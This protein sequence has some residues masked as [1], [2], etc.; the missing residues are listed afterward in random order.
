V[1]RIVGVDVG[2][3]FT[4]VVMLDDDGLTGRKV[5]TTRNQ[6]DGVIAAMEQARLETRDLF[7]HG[8]TAGTNALLE[9]TGARTALVTTA[10]F[11]DIIEIA[12]QARPSLYDPFD[13]RP[14]PL[15]PPELRFGYD[16]DPAGLTQRLIEAA[17]EAIALALVRSHLDPEDELDLGERL[18]LGTG[19]PVSVGAVVSPEFREYERVATT[20]L[21]AYLTP[22]LALYLSRL[23]R[24]LETEQRLVM[25]S[26]GGLLTFASAT[27]R[28]GRLALS[29]P[30]AGAVAATAMG[31]A[32]GY[33]SVISFDMGG[34]STDVCRIHGAGSGAAFRRVAGRVNRV[35]SLPVRT[36]GAGGGSLAWVDDAGALRVGPRSAGSDP[37]PA[38]YGKGGTG[39]TVTDANVLL[40]HIPP[41]L[42][43]GGS[44]ALDMDAARAALGSIG[45]EAGFDAETAARGIVDV[46][47][48][49]M[50]GALR[51]VSV[52]EGSDP[53][54]SVL[55]AFGGSG[56]LH[57]TNL[58]KRLGIRKVLIP[59]L[60]G[61]FSALGLL[62]ARPS[63]DAV[64]TVMLEEGST[65][66]E[67]D[68]RQILARAR[69]AFLSDH[70]RPPDHETT[71]ADVRYAGQSHE[72][73]VAL[74]DDWQRLRSEFEDLHRSRFGFILP[75]EPIEVV[76]VRGE[77]TAPAPITWVDIPA[78]PGRRG[79]GESGSPVVSRDRL[80]PGDRLLGP[81]AVIESD[82]AVWLEHDDVLTVHEDGTLEIE[83]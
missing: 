82:S 79:E 45:Q 56:G 51:A 67:T 15:V 31:R 75:G 5:P 60:S 83:W 18:E 50:E 12:R 9:E 22:T 71:R 81:V 37:G 3:T 69:A 53:S 20:V 14:L 47:N 1:P 11:E 19:I 13:D 74:G 55:V 26:S 70:G 66:L 44:V 62:L 34:T 49:H 16:G 4:D 25:T 30:A 46:V 28:A 27:R 54:D 57:A 78:L 76:N 41:S 35:P 64:M 32:K 61:V 65:R 24:S 73:T 68:R 48:T 58:A 2:G 23:D 7:L 59:P 38:S 21:D 40:G 52:E 29:G 80:A 6:A 10:G 17:P 33:A 39:A 43:L 63:N 36:I 77:V 42:S 8:T 72:L